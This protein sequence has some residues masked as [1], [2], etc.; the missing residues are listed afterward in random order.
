MNAIPSNTA[1]RWPLAQA[2]RELVVQP[3]VVMARYHRDELQHPDILLK[4]MVFILFSALFFAITS[5]LS[6]PALQAQVAWQMVIRFFF[7]FGGMLLVIPMMT[8]A[9]GALSKFGSWYLNLTVPAV[10]V[11]GVAG[12]GTLY[13]ALM[14]LVAIPLHLLPLAPAVL[15]GLLLG[16]QLGAIILNFRLFITAYRTLGEVSFRKALLVSLFPLIII[17]VVVGLTQLLTYFALHPHV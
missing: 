7:F 5:V 6:F 16:L 15:Q 13:F 10:K 17:A 2:I 1:T 8:I 14:F 12:L 11:I 9:W 4:A 3:G